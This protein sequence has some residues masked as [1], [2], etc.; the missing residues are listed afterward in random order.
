[1]LKFDKDMMYR[2]VILEHSKN[3][4]NFKEV[5]GL[6]VYHSK[7]PLCGDN[8]KLQ[9]ELDNQNKIQNIY[10]KSKGCSISVSS[11]SIL[12]DLLK[13]KTVEQALYIAENFVKMASGQEFDK[14]LDFKD[15]VV[16]E[17]I[18][19]YPA[20]QSCATVGWKLVIDAL[21][22]KDKGE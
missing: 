12:T 3:P 15:G 21:K 4:L 2:E 11:V 17:N 7:N 1:M 20:R 9:I 10:H 6:E 14:E 5:D 16:F 22:N 8:V 18:K 19:N 13:N